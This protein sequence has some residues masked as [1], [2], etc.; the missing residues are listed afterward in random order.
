M[1]TRDA[2]SERPIR[3]DRHIGLDGVGLCR[4]H[5]LMVRAL[6]IERLAGGITS[7]PAGTGVSAC[8]GMTRAVFTFWSCSASWA[9][10]SAS[11]ST[12]MC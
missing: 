12:P 6:R 4:F 5:K 9:S 8:P 11:G 2:Q 3:A 10:V 7:R 1:L